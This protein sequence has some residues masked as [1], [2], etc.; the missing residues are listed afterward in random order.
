M[1]LTPEKE[2]RRT[3]QFYNC[4]VPTVTN[5]THATEF[6]GQT[7]PA[8][9]DKIAEKLKAGKSVKN[10][11]QA[12]HNIYAKKLSI[13]P[14][15]VMKSNKINSAA[16]YCPDLYSTGENRCAILYQ[17]KALFG[18]P[19]P[20]ISIIIHETK[21]AQQC[22]NVNNYIKFGVLPKS[23]KEK[24]LLIYEFFYA[25]SFTQSNK[26]PYF[27]KLCEID[28]YTFELFEISKLN[29]KYPEKFNGLGYYETLWYKMRNILYDFKYN[30]N[31]LN[32]TGLKQVY[33]AIKTDIYRSRCGEYGQEMQALC[34]R[35]NLSGFNLE[36][37]FASIIKDLDVMHEITVSLADDVRSL[38]YKA[39]FEKH[40]NLVYSKRVAEINPKYTSSNLEKTFFIMSNDIDD[41]FICG[42]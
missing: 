19:T 25:Y 31:G 29:E 6:D 35:L 13:A 27:L 38:G 24:L 12:I 20:F 4:Y 1:K 10:L 37:A 33:K 41:E 16:I 36:K 23:D 26:L 14:V 5:G 3:A 30:K 11:A 7:L 28:A 39:K 40:G 21:H 15:R 34:I 17:Q 22:Y 9:Y 8:L 32:S 18:G 42:K 2:K